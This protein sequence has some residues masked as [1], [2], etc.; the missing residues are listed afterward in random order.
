LAQLE[1]I[2]ELV[3]K[4]RRIFRGYQARLGEVR[5]IKLNV[6]RPWARNICWMTSIVLDDALQVDRDDVIA[7]LKARQVDSRPFFPPISSFP[8]FESRATQNP[9]AH[10]IARRGINLPS[11][12]NLTEDDVNYVCF[13]LRE[14]LGAR[15]RKAA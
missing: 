2:E 1:R 6:E 14:V 12:H 9:V 8:M 4:K 13:A 3:A 5:G 15:T 10:R 7:G 11:G